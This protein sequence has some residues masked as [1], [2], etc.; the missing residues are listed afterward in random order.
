ML[1]QHGLASDE[2]ASKEIE[3]V[4]VFLAEICIV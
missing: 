2:Q 4:Q 1:S 3:H